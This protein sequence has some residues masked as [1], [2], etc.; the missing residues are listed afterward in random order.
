MQGPAKGKPAVL[1]D[2]RKAGPQHQERGINAPVRELG[3]ERTEAQRAVEKLVEE[4]M[5]G[6]AGLASDRGSVAHRRVIAGLPP[7]RRGG[8]RSRGLASSSNALSLV[9]SLN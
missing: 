5:W 7:R 6:C 9:R 1:P 2:G 8:A 3:I 4:A